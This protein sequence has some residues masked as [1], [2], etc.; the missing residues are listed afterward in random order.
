MSYLIKRNGLIIVSIWCLSTTLVQAQQETSANPPCGE[1][2]YAGIEIGGSGIKAVVVDSPDPTEPD[3]PFAEDKGEQ[4]PNP[5]ADIQQSGEIAEGTL[6]EIGDAVSRLIQ[7]IQTEH[8]V[9]TDH[10]YIVGSS[11]VAVTKNIKDVLTKMV[12]DKTD[13]TMDFI[14]VEDEACSQLKPANEDFNNKNAVNRNS[15]SRAMLLDIGSSNIKGCYQQKF[16]SQQTDL[17]A[18]EDVGMRVFEVKYGTKRFSVFVANPKSDA[19]ANPKSDA[20][21]KEFAQLASQ[22]WSQEVLPLLNVEVEKKPE[23]QSRPQIYLTGGIVWIMVTSLAPKDKKFQNRGLHEI[24]SADIPKFYSAVTKDAQAIWNTLTKD[25]QTKFTPRDL[26]AGA[27]ILRGL[28][29]H[30]K[31]RKKRVFWWNNSTSWLFE[32][33]LAKAKAEID[34]K[35]ETDAKQ[36]GEETGQKEQNKP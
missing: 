23:F 7:K 9:A 10:I 36:K 8:K 16:S 25:A 35:A 30:L 14:S 5:S 1:K 28:S 34:A 29:D 26:I 21:D 24:A 31:F 22:S 27:Q 2:C 3:K 6:R 20:D 19:V 11:G 15:S 17:L 12:L 32:Y 18:N 33:T 13:R 4:S